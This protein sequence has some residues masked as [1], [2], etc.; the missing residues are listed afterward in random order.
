MFKLESYLQQFN[1]QCNYSQQSGAQQSSYEIVGVIGIL[2]KL[3]VVLGNLT[4]LRAVAV[5]DVVVF[6]FSC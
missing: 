6:V 4:F 5:H 2:N 3:L 1:S